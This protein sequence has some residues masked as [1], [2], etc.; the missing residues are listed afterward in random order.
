[1]ASGGIA[2]KA[3]SLEALFHG[4][5]TH[6]IEYCRRE[7]AWGPDEVSTLLADR[8]DHCR[9][10]RS[11]VRWLAWSLADDEEPALQR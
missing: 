3:F 4:R 9:G 7:Y 5:V 2:G 8:S 1:M 6:A 11:W 10:V